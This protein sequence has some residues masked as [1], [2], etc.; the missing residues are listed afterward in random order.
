MGQV[1]GRHFPSCA[2]AGTPSRVHTRHREAAAWLCARQEGNGLANARPASA[3]RTFSSSNV[4]SGKRRE[5]SERAG[6]CDAGVGR[7][8]LQR[9]RSPAQKPGAGRGHRWLQTSASARSPPA[10][11][12]HRRWW[13]ETWVQ[14]SGTEGAVAARSEP[15]PRTP[16]T[17][18][19]YLA[20]SQLSPGPGLSP[21]VHVPSLWL[22]AGHRA[23][24]QMR[25]QKLW[26]LKGSPRPSTWR[27]SSAL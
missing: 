4:P 27:L 7:R 15:L 17:S 9:P 18:P 5:G 12:V 13:G 21:P 6:P 26:C 3:T 14:V 1:W 19:L 25:K 8:A 10:R 23:H 2:L 20:S 11:G 16:P 22:D 24:L